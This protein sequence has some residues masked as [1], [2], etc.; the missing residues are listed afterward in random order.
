MATKDG[1][2]EIWAYVGPKA[3]MA[4]ING[5]RGWLMYLEEPSDTGFSSRNPEYDGPADARIE[6]FLDN[7]QRDEYPASWAYPVGEINRAL[8]YF[9]REGERPAFIDWHRDVNR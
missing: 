1:F 8:D 2:K 3:M 4:L 6:Y 9:R 5:D 7:G